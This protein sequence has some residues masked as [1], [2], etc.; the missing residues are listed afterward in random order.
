MILLRLISWPYFR[1]HLL[2]TALTTAGIVIGVALFVAVRVANN[3]VVS[4]F[5]GTVDRI[6]GKPNLRSRR[7]KPGSGKKFSSA[8]RRRPPCASPC[9]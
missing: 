1:K 6:A 3:S 8:C 2:R 4:G 9:Q 5:S 7:A